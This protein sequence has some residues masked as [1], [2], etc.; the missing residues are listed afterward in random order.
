[1]SSV[2]IF[3]K[4]EDAILA[5]AKIIVG[6][7]IQFTGRCL[8][9]KLVYHSL[10]QLNLSCKCIIHLILGLTDAQKSIGISIAYEL[11]KSLEYYLHER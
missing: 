3:I 5:T 1:M 10:A 6:V 7:C 9:D 8:I 2:L 11:D 4:R